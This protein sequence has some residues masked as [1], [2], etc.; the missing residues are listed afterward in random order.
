MI[1]MEKTNKTI[2]YYNSNEAQYFGN[3]VNADMSEC[4]ERFLKYVVPGDRII[5]IGA[6]S[7]RAIKYFNDRGYIVES[8]DASKEMCQL[9]TDYSGVE[10]ICE[11]IQD[12]YPQKSMMVYGQTHLC[13][14][15]HFLK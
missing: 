12:W 1:N 6:G 10:V 4:C 9:A 7:G 2:D 14:I 5:D 13:C 15:F 11:R 3:T 8:I